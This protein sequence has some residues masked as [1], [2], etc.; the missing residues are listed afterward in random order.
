MSRPNV[1]MMKRLKNEYEKIVAE[2]N[3]NVY[4]I[5]KPDFT[6]PK[7]TGYL[8]NQYTKTKYPFYIKFLNRYPHEPPKVFFYK[9]RPPIPVAFT[10]LGEMCL[11]LLETFKTAHPEYTD[12]WSPACSINTLLISIQSMIKKR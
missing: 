6:I 12:S 5:E 9:K 1:F 11:D 7:W 4:H 2:N 8:I 3:T 10:T